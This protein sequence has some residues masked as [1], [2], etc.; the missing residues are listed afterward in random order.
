MNAV[1]EWREAN[2]ANKLIYPRTHDELNKVIQ[3]LTSKEIKEQNGL[4]KSALIR[5][6]YDV[7]PLIDYGSVSRVATTLIRSGM[8]PLEAVQLAGALY[9]SPEYTPE[10]IP[11]VENIHKVTKLLQSKKQEREI[12][13]TKEPALLEPF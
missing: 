4:P 7:Q 8:H 2:R 11:L 6:Y 5:D 10:T 1:S 12:M 9:L 3:K 13:S